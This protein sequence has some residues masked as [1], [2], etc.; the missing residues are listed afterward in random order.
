MS[1]SPGRW[2]FLI[3]ASLTVAANALG[4][5]WD[6]PRPPKPDVPYLLHARN[7]V[8]LEVNQASEQRRRDKLIYTIPGPHSTAKTP[9]PEPMFLFLSEKIRPEDLEI[10]RLEVRDGM[11]QIVF[12]QDDPEDNPR[13]IRFTIKKL[14]ENLYLIEVQQILENGEYSISPRGSNVVFCFQEY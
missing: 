12:D 3:V 14:D 7:L 11:R 4:A 13:P 1:F 8:E 5:K 9:V 6:G 2:L 10:Y